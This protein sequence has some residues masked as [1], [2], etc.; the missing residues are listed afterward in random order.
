MRSTTTI[1]AAVA[2]AFALTAPAHAGGDIIRTDTGL[3]SGA[4]GSFQGIP[5]AA[6]PVGANRW[7]DPQPVTPWQGVRDATRPGPRCAQDEGLG[8]PASD[9]EDCLYLNVTRPDDARN[10][11]VLVWVHGGGFTSG[12][13][14]DYGVDQL[15]RA[16]NVVVTFNYRL[17]AFGYFGHP[18]L[19]G[20]GA[21]GLADQQ[22]ALDW[23]RRN[24][25]GSAATRTTSRCSARRRA[26]CRRARS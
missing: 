16:G 21:F 15:V 23:V 20:S 3:V 26:G 6:P 12:A 2:A 7:R 9:A 14:S 1:F 19:A 5:F 25:R 24:I 4:R 22:A 18:G 10:R 8:S 17:G 11:P 13:G